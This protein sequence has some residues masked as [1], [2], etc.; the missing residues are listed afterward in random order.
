MKNLESHER[1][2]TKTAIMFAITLSFLIFA[3]NTFTLLGHLMISQL[4]SSLGADLYG[5]AV[6][7]RNI[8]AVIDD[9]RIS[10]YLEEQKEEFKDVIGWTYVSH[11][12]GAVMKKVSDGDYGKLKFSDE[13]GQ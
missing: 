11:D 5:M 1:R 10:S 6:D 9:K 12:L 8:G 7:T 2:N 3:G 13:T 4:E